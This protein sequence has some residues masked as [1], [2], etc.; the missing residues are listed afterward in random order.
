MVDLKNMDNTND[1]IQN[2]SAEKSRIKKKIL[3]NLTELYFLRNNG[4]ICDFHIWSSRDQ[5]SERIA[6][7]EDDDLFDDHKFSQLL[8]LNFQETTQET[9]TTT[10]STTTSTNTSTTTTTSATNKHQLNDSISQPQEKKARHDSTKEPPTSRGKES[11]THDTTAESKPM[12]DSSTVVDTNEQLD[13]SSGAKSTKPEQAANKSEIDDGEPMEVDN[14]VSITK[15]QDEHPKD[16]NRRSSQA[17]I[18]Q[19]SGKSRKEQR[20]DEALVKETLVEQPN[21]K[22]SEPSCSTAD[23]S[24]A[25]TSSKRSS[26]DEHTSDRVKISRTQT[27]SSPA[28]EDSPTRISKAV[29]TIVTP[30]AVIAEN[31]HRQQQDRVQHESA[32]QSRILEL[33]KLGLWTAKR[34]P[35]LQ[36]PPRP[37]THWDC[38]LEEARW[39]HNDYRNERK[40]KRHAAR[41][42]AYEAYK[43]VN[44]QRT[45]EERIVKAKIQY[46]RKIA[47]TL[48]KEVRSFWG[49]IEKIVDFRQQAKLEET[50]KKAYGLHLN[51][52]LDQTSKFSNTFVEEQ[53]QTEQLATTQNEISYLINKDGDGDTDKKETV[54]N[55]SIYKLVA[56]THNRLTALH[57]AK[58]FNL[59]SPIPV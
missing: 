27:Y 5:F 55:V 57:W 14:D 9:T 8:N 52:I 38:L 33:R 21:N 4:Q 50:R 47:A 13:D 43:Y 20:N 26:S 32:V 58:N 48:S 54:I 2:L 35:K 25:V 37:K 22:F 28:K 11:L 53:P 24:P 29:E 56:S 1:A 44:H 49:S 10:S 41:K 23:G 30:A 40:W 6:Q 17:E 34:L 45:Q 12:V 7:T 18:T 59:P 51:Y 31:N 39:L 46:I 42:V 15:T 19:S 3:E 16:H 36:E